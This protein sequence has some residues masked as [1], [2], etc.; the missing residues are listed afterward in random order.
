M[1]LGGGFVITAA[2][3]L[4]DNSGIATGIA[5]NAAGDNSVALAEAWAIADTRFVAI[6]LLA[7]A[8]SGLTAAG[9]AR[10]DATHVRVTTGVEQAGGAASILVAIDVLVLCFRLFGCATPM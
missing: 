9:V 8:A 1:K 2:A 3:A 4:A 7:I 10:P 5:N 6:P